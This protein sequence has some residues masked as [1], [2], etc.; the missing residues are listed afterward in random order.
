MELNIRYSD[1]EAIQLER[2]KNSHGVK[3]FLDPYTGR[4]LI[5]ITN[6]GRITLKDIKPKGLAS[7]AEVL[8]YHLEEQFVKDTD[9]KWR[10]K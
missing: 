7:L 2:Q 3:D 8:N 10:N 1:I 6:G 4:D 5:I 9:G